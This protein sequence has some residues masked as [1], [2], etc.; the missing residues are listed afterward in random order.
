M[1]VIP[2]K[3]MTAAVLGGILGLERESKHKP[4]GL[5]TCIVI[6]VASCLLTIVSIE[7]STTPYANHLIRVDPMRL[8]AQIVSGV[9]FLGAGVILQRNNAISGLTTAAIV[10]AASG[11][12]I[13][14]GAGFFYE[15]ALGVALIFLGVKVIPYIMRKIGPSALREQ[16]IKITVYIESENEIGKV[17]KDIQELGITMK[18]VKL[19][20]TDMGHRLDLQ[21]TIEEREGYIFDIYNRV[22]ELEGIAKVQIEE[23]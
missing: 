8:A 7:V 14:V 10:W 12:G 17:V 23:F 20:G 11:L 16:G 13:A 2:I 15:S 22:T 19:A 1:W 3:L 4:L 5:K 6:S 18:H 21:C 9:G